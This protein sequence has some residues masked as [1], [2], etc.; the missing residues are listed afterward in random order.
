MTSNEIIME[1]MRKCRFE[2]IKDRFLEISEEAK[3]VIDSAGSKEIL[4]LS[5][6]FSSPKVIKAEIF[7]EQ[8][9]IDLAF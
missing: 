6:T 4:A 3:E 7:D 5:L 2:K 1:F 9:F 8:K